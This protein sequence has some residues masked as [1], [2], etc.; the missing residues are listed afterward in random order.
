MSIVSKVKPAI[1]DTGEKKEWYESWFDSP[2]YHALY[3]HRDKKEAE[4]FLDNLISHLHPAPGSRI[5]DVACGRGRHSLYL[6]SK[7]FDVT[8]FDLSPEN[9]KYD[10]QFENETLT[11][12]LH[13]MR[14]LF[15]TNYFDVVINL[16][17]SFGYFQKSHDN[18]RCLH[19]NCIAMKKNGFFVLD[20]FNS[21]TVR[22]QADST[23]ELQ[24]DAIRFNILKSVKEDMVVKTIRV[25]D[26]GQEFVYE[27]RVLLLDL[28]TLTSWLDLA[29]LKVIDV[30]G[31][32]NLDPFI[33]SESERLIITACKK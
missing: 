17:S 8:G 32:Y 33:P 6:N 15:R 23:S 28:D 31:N 24:I 14:E 4:I 25:S 13:D 11:F 19:A 12:Y 21:R 27:E 18:I 1:P 29:G 26:H 9:I 16:F 3:R 5:L 30:M 22:D 7:G 20:Y 2:Y 10:K